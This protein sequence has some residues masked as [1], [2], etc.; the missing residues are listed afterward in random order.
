VGYL[1]SLRKLIPIGLLVAAAVAFAMVYAAGDGSAQ[2]GV[3]VASL[4]Q[5]T[6]PKN[7]SAGSIADAA[8][9]AASVSS[10]AQDVKALGALDVPGVQSAELLRSRMVVYSTGTMVV[11]KLNGLPVADGKRAVAELRDRLTQRASSV[12][13]SVGGAPAVITPI[14]SPF[15]IEGSGVTRSVIQSWV[16]ALVAG[17]VVGIGVIVMIDRLWA[18]RR[19]AQSLG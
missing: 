3:S 10:L 9:V 15:E 11:V 18:R 16:L 8:A 19:R 2:T 13:M 12:G 17:A 5:V 4:A 7:S 1:W 6:V 14:G